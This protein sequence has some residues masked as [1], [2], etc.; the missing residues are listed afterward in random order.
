MKTES[1]KLRFG[2]SLAL[3]IVRT[4]ALRNEPPRRTHSKVELGIQTGY[5]PSGGG[6]NNALSRL[7]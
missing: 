7:R 4:N 6:F 2:D 1:A 3:P 5:E